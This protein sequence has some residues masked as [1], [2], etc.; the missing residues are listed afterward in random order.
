MNIKE[1][2]KLIQSIVDAQDNFIVIIENDIPV[3]MNKAFVKF[4]GVSSYEQYTKEFGLFENNFVPHPSYFNKDKI[5]EGKSWIDSLLA[6]NEKDQIV[7]MINTLHEP[8][9]FKVKIDDSHEN[10]DVCTFNDISAD[11]IK[12]IMIE[13]DASM[14]KRSGAYNKDYFLHTSEILQDGASFNEKFVGLSMIKILDELESLKPIVSD[15]K[16]VI[17][18]NDMLIKWSKDILLV[19]YLVDNKENAILFTNKLKDVIKKHTQSK[20]V[21]D[22][23]QK[24]EKISSAIKKVQQRLEE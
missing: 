2:H 9:A 10:Y 1:P 11:L 17:R 24:D 15:I 19:A 5:E 8:R 3:L 4:F 20:I 12:C 21:V 13:N 16:E 23:V 14:D 7:S 22:I 18:Q 6:L